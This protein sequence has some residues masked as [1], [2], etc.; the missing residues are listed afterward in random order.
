MGDHGA[1]N[2]GTSRDQPLSQPGRQR[3]ILATRFFF[4]DGSSSQTMAREDPNMSIS[5]PISKL[6]LTLT[7]CLFGITS[8]AVAKDISLSWDPNLESDVAGYKVYYGTSAGTYT[9][10]GANTGPAPIDFGSATSATL[11]GLDDNKTHYITVTA[12]NFN[13]E[14][15]TYSNEVNAPPQ[16]YNDL[17]GDGYD[18]SV[19]CD[20]YKAEINPGAVEIHN[21]GID[22]NCNGM[23]D[24]AQIGTPGGAIEAESGNLTA[25]MQIVADSAA[26]GGSYIQT[27][28]SNSGTASYNFNISAPGVYKIVARVF[29]ADSGN[30]FRRS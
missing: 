22:E 10:T 6:F 14:E 2:Y 12:Y 21:N 4:T 30:Q 11:V 7:L 25:P 9:G 8:F 1:Q 27:S 17:D 26:A 15:S 13:G 29:A 18:Q 19:D 24:D 28:T 16:S 20:D 5:H 3:T 23:N